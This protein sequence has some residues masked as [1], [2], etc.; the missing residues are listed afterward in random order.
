MSIASVH[1]SPNGAIFYNRHLTGSSIPAVTCVGYSSPDSADVENDN[2]AEFIWYTGKQSTPYTA[3]RS[4]SSA[5]KSSQTASGTVS[6][7]VDVGGCVE[8]Y[9]TPRDYDA[10]IRYVTLHRSPTSAALSAIYEDHDTPRR[11]TTSVSPPPPLHRAKHREKSGTK[12]VLGSGTA[13]SGRR[14]ALN[15]AFVGDDGTS[16]VKRGQS[17]DGDADKLAAFDSWCSRVSW[18]A[19]L[20]AGISSVSAATV[21]DDVSPNADRRGSYLTDVLDSVRFLSG[22]NPS[23]AARTSGVERQSRV[24]VERTRPREFFPSFGSFSD[25]VLDSEFESDNSKSFSASAVVAFA[26]DVNRR[27]RLCLQ[28]SSADSGLSSEGQGSQVTT[29]ISDGRQFYWRPAVGM[30]GELP[31]PVTPSEYGRTTYYTYGCP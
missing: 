7:N 29:D 9:N 10:D 4:G 25:S 21:S 6:V 14:G 31:T 12:S 5:T 2:D 28:R 11:A 17:V 16:S 3:A 26:D 19:N 23:D 30:M 27:R 22:G 24:A 15:T 20:Q 8:L 13:W 1:Q 18:R